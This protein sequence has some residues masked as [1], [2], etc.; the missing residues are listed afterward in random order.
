MTRKIEQC[1]AIIREVDL[2][3][4]LEPK[5]LLTYHWRTYAIIQMTNNL[6]QAILALNSCAFAHIAEILKITDTKITRLLDV[7]EEDNEK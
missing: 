6:A 2:T 5:D 3:K 7:E 4:G 1:F